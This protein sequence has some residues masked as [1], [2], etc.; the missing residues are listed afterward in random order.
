MVSERDLLAGKVG[1]E[2]EMLKRL[3]KLERKMEQ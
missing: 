2:Q 1:L 3:E